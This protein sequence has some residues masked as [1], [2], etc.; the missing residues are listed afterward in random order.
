VLYNKWV[1]STVI[2]KKKD[3]LC[4]GIKLE[5]I[6]VAPLIATMATAIVKFSTTSVHSVK[7]SKSFF[8]LFIAQN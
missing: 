8:A 2:L 1:E 6:G 3:F 5:T 7:A 4:S